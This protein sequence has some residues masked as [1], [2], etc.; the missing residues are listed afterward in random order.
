[1]GRKNTIIKKYK[2]KR[3][4][5]TQEIYYERYSYYFFYDF[6]ASYVFYIFL[7][8]AAAFSD[9]FD[10]SSAFYIFLDFL[11]VSSSFDL[12]RRRENIKDYRKA[13]EAQKS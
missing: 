1:M 4:K 9:L 8:L 6:Y 7:N 13:S 12:S 3:N 11:T 10:V 2:N 5:I